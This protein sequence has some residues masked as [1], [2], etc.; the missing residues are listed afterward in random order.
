M[1]SH[2]GQS[3]PHCGV[4]WSVEKNEFG[5]VTTTVPG[6]FN[7]GPLHSR[8]VVRLGFLIGAF[9]VGGIAKLMHDKK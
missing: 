2:A 8:G 6:G 7:N 1:T 4:F 3:C 5:Q 9:V